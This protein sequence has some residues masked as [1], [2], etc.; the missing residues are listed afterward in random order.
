ML[1]LALIESRRR[2]RE[3]I[4]AVRVGIQ[5]RR[6]FRMCSQW[7]R[8][9]RTRLWDRSGFRRTRGAAADMAVR[10]VHSESMSAVCRYQLWYRLVSFELGSVPG[11]VGASRSRC[12]R[13]R[14]ADGAVTAKEASISNSGQLFDGS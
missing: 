10:A 13:R 8:R 1:G 12:R 6:I 4:E 11:D 7:I 2:C 5:T 3:L 14:A 9:Q